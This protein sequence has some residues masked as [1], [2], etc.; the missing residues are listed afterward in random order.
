M[1]FST[2][3]VISA[4]LSSS[5][6]YEI[7]AGLGAYVSILTPRMVATR[8]SVSLWWKITRFRDLD[9]CCFFKIWVYSLVA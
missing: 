6:F 9:L 2:K 1:K 4:K 5:T 3:I 8:F 7:R